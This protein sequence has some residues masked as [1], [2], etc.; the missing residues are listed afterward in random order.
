MKEVK[1]EEIEAA[2]EA[3]IEAVTAHLEAE[4][5][6]K[7][8]LPFTVYCLRVTVYRLLFTV[9]GLRVTGLPVGKTNGHCNTT[10]NP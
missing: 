2:I 5:D 4:G 8:G 1:E 9:Y 6:F 7:V 3:A 10:T